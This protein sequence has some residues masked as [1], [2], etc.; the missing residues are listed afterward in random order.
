VVGR[1]KKSSGHGEIFQTEKLAPV[2]E[3]TNKRTWEV[4]F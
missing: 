2:I 4:F 3:V 1:S